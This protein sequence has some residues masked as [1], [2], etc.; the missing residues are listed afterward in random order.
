MISAHVIPD[1]FWPIIV[2]MDHTTSKYKVS[3]TA[4]AAWLLLESGMKPQFASKME[5]DLAQACN[6]EVSIHS[7]FAVQCLDL[8]L[9]QW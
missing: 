6:Y 7:S 8:E 5:Q 9:E 1:S 2:I 3:I 4:G